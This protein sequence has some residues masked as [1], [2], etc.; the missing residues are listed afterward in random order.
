MNTST[1]LKTLLSFVLIANLTGCR[2][3]ELGETQVSSDPHSDT[4][5]SAITLISGQADD[6]TG[7]S[8]A[9]Q[10]TAV[11]WKVSLIESAF[12]SSAT[13]SNCG[14]AFNQ[15]CDNSAGTKTASYSS[16]SVGSRGFLLSGAVTLTYSNNSCSLGV[17][18]NVVRTFDHTLSGPH[19]GAVQTTSA[20]RTNYRGTQLGGGGRL[21]H[22][23]STTWEMEL[24]GKH[25]IGT[26]N[27]RTLFDISAQTTS[28]LVIDGA[29]SR[30]GRTISAGS[31][32]V[33]HNLAQFSA[34]Y[35]V[36]QPLVWNSTC[37]HPVSGALSAIY[38]GSI[39][40]QG[41]ITFSGCGSPQLS[42]DGRT[43]TLSI[44]YC[45]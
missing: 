40:G 4:L 15:T 27:G 7:E 5:E 30:S 14:R 41:T 33:S 35:A 38:S 11:D 25:K 31:I 8:F 13:A 34:V 19:G 12:L 44:G 16:C 23:A 1:I 28:P 17:G 22:T 9:L 37:C 39:S 3:E 21:S 18:E 43:R 6:A 42:K 10:K 29:L 45:D 2:E 36:T 26:R 20:L 32:E 24:L